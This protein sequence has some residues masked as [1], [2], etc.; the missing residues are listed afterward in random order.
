MLPVYICD[1]QKDNLIML[2]RFVNEHIQTN[3]YDMEIC[4]STSCPELL[5]RKISENKGK[6][7]IYFLDVDLH[8]ETIDG[9]TL[10]KEIR[11][12]DG[13]G[14]IIYIT[15]FADLAYKTFQYH[16]E[17]LDYIIKGNKKLVHEMIG[18]NLKTII[19]RQDENKESV[20]ELK[21]F[22]TIKYIKT[23]DIF[24]FETTN[25]SHRI[26]LHGKYEVIDFIGNIKNIQNLLK[27]DFVRSHR[28]YLINTNNIKKIDFKNNVV[29]MGNGHS[30]L[31]SRETKKY[32]LIISYEKAT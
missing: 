15:A 17:A 24:Y 2:E 1:D 32:F 21:I 30:C 9:F 29:I 20:F 28:S 8:H 16:V 23:S 18:N 7:A 12:M 22:D 5:I 31:L 11:K 14:F 27:N 10:G 19:K 4:C 3:N 6:R 13:Q 25:K 26:K